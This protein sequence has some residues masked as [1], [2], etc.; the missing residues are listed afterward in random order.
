MFLLGF[1]VSE[2]LRLHHVAVA[3][4][5]MGRLVLR[6]FEVHFLEQVLVADVNV[7]RLFSLGFAARPL[8]GLHEHVLVLAFEPLQ[9]VEVHGLR[10]DH[11]LYASGLHCGPHGLGPFQLLGLTVQSLSLELR[12]L[13]VL[14]LLRLFEIQDFDLAIEVV[15]RNLRRAGRDRVF[16][17]AHLGGPRFELL[18]IPPVFSEQPT[19]DFGFDFFVHLEAVFVGKTLRD[20]I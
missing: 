20:S 9:V 15:V 6:L 16:E 13:V 18:G 8:L 5:R 19:H 10:P 17:T 2:R 12:L 14:Q 1:H 7:V 4:I 11:W 3:F